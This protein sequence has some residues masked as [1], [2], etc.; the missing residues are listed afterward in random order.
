MSPNSPV[1]RMNCTAH[2]TVRAITNSEQSSSIVHLSMK[3]RHCLTPREGLE[4]LA[5]SIFDFT[6]VR[7]S[8]TFSF[9]SVC[10]YGRVGRAA[11]AA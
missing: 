7:V 2:H 8:V 9:I 10:R 11:I 1:K 4:S 6:P 5:L 3:Y